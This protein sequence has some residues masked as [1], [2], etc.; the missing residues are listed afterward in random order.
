MSTVLV[1]E[2]DPSLRGFLRRQIPTQYEI[3]EAACPVEALDICRA[4]C[5]I[6]VLLCDVELGLVSG[7]E[8]A[9]LLR[10]WHSRLRTI[11]LSDLPCDKWSQRWETELKELPA[12]DVLILEKP[13]KPIELRSTVSTLMAGVAVG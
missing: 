13:F 10:A 2:R 12:D 5:E 4:H 3:L 11:L 9:S 7:I 1:V 6:D 8:L